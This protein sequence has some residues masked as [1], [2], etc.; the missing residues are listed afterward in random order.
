MIGIIAFPKIN[1]TQSIY[2]D[3]YVK[4]VELSGAKAFVI[5]YTISQTSL[6]QCLEQ[7]NGIVWTGG[8]IHSADY[9]DKQYSTYMNTLRICFDIAKTYNEMGRYFPIWGTCLGFE[10]L[11]LFGK[12]IKLQNIFQHLK[13]HLKNGKECI[14]FTKSDTRL[15]KWFSADMRK[16]METIPC[17]THHHNYGFD[18]DSMQHVQHVSINTDFINAMEYKNYPFYGVQFHPE[19]PFD[20]FSRE[21]S[22]QFS[23]FLKNECFK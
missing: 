7:L 10:I 3:R 19:K 14:S 4:W 9:S 16:K 18:E 8:N 17:S 5:P 6:L 12:K 2:P 15:K 20:A 23:L 1:S 11:V 22:L 13:P 21:V